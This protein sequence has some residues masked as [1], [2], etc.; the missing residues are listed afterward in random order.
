MTTGS[1]IM[2]C[3]ALSDGN[4][5]DDDDTIAIIPIKYSISNQ[6]QQPHL[7]I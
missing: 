6:K 5:N 4:D 7:N 2:Y 1:I 3:Q